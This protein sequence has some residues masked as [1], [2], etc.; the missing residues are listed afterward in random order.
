[1]CKELIGL[2]TR[3]GLHHGSIVRTRESQ[4]DPQIK[5]NFNICIMI[6]RTGCLNLNKI[7]HAILT[8]LTKLIF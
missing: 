4:H 8:L 2:W 3:L 6:Q 7:Q 5:F 1:M